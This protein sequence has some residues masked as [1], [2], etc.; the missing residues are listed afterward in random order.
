MKRLNCERKRK[1]KL[2]QKKEADTEAWKEKVKHIIPILIR[3]GS[4]KEGKIASFVQ[5]RNYLAKK[6][7]VKKIDLMFWT[8]ENIV[9]KWESLNS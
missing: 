3:T 5:I 6:Y 2:K 7:K 1:R 4:S 9:E 8:A